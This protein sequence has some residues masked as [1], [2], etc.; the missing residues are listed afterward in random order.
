MQVLLM[1][2]ALSAR[3]RANERSNVLLLTVAASAEESAGLETVTRERL[4]RLDVQLELR[5]VRSIDLTEMRRPAL[6]AYFARVWITLAAGGSARLYLEHGPSDRLLVR[7]VPGD[8]ANPELVREELGHILQAAVEGLKAGQ[9]VGEPREQVLQQVAPQARPVAPR[10]EPKAPPAAAPR[11]P[12]LRFGARYEV[13]WLGAGPRLEDGPGAVIA[14]TAGV[15]VELSG[16]YRRPIRVERE[17]VGARLE[18]IS[19]RALASF[20]PSRQLRLGAGLGADFVH[21]RPLAQAGQGLDLEEAGVRRLALGRLQATYGYRVGRFVELEISAGAD[22]D[23]SGTRYVV[24]RGSGQA[25]IFSPA[26]LR[27]FI[28]LGAA[29]P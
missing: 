4:E 7:D 20:E 10:H 12:L 8:P 21:V 18:T 28:S 16:Y 13:R 29:L 23:A 6:H 9:E 26:P 19:L 17:P 11:R 5:R 14:I 1:L 27:P 22:V 25:S 24:Q 3:A 15:G 2:L